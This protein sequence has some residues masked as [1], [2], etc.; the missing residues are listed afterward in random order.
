M[1]ACGIGDFYVAVH[2]DAQ[3]TAQAV[4]RLRLQL[5]KMFC[6]CVEPGTGA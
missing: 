3:F 5:R 4:E 6:N 2:S 1:L